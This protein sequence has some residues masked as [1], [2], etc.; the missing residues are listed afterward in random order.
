MWR[1]SNAMGKLSTYSALYSILAAE[2][3]TGMATANENQ[4]Q[5]LICQ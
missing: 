2:N 3:N 4:R 1:E 5:Q